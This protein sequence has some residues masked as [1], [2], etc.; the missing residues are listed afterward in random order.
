MLEPQWQRLERTFTASSGLEGHLAHHLAAEPGSPGRPKL[1]WL[2]PQTHRLVLTLSAWE[3]LPG[4]LAHHLAAEAF[5]DGRAK[6]GTAEPHWQGCALSMA[7]ASPGFEGQ[8]GHHLAAVLGSPGRTKHGR[9]RLGHSQNFLSFMDI[10]SAGLDGHKA[11][12][13]TDP[14]SV[15]RANVG[16]R[17]PHSQR[18]VEGLA[19]ATASAGLEGHL[20]HHLA[21]SLGSPGRARLGARLRPH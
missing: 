4:H 12:H 18:H 9:L 14:G 17:L 1:G 8:L 20:G 10:V 5:S 7:T 11:H 6:L 19:T 15:G 3:G 13:R 21:A 2:A 16:C